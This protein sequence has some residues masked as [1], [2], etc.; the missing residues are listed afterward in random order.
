MTT[1]G[2]DA[3]H[4]PSETNNDIPEAKDSEPEADGESPDTEDGSPEAD[5]GQLGRAE[6]SALHQKVLPAL[7]TVY[8]ENG[9]GTGFLIEG[10]LVVTAYHVAPRVKRRP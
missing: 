5:P 6:L 4:A 1:D 2:Q 10:G 3:E 8:R 9:R 7:V